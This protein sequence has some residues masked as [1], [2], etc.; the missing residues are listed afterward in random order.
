MIMMDHQ[1]QI[2][3]ANSLALTLFGYTR[4]DLMEQPIEVLVPERFRTNHPQKR[5]TFLANPTPRAMGNGGDLFGLRKDGSEFP[6]EI[7]LNPVHTEDG[8]FVLTSVVDITTRKMY[9]HELK[10]QQETL[11]RMVEQ[12]T[13]DLLDAKESA[14]KANAAKTEILANMSH[15]LRTPMHAIL[16]FTHLAEKKLATHDP[17]HIQRFL[18]QIAE[19]GN[20]LL[21]LLNDLL[22]ISK[23]ESGKVTYN[24]ERHDLRETIHRV[25][26]ESESLLQEKQLQFHVN[27]SSLDTYIE[28]DSQKM[29]Q[30]FVN[31]LS[32]AIKFSP[33]GKRILVTMR[34]TVANLGRRETDSTPEAALRITFEDRGVGIPESELQDIFDKFIQSSKTKT[35]A[36]GTGLGLAICKEIIEAHRG[37]I[38]AVN[39]PEGGTMFTIILPISHVRHPQVKEACNVR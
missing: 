11:Q 2:V 16:S 25:A 1:G 5:Q 28:Y 21:F 36:G 27:E 17:E 13:R 10:Y 31:L 24:I 19:S 12:R 20:R 7:G 8:M 32:N 23:L 30:V 22:D 14:E 3:L 34:S 39:C 35:G 4:D 18:S 26:Q 38:W 33:K 37:K 15:E 9:E 6:I 29:H